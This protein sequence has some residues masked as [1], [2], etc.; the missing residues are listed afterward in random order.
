MP[1]QR[2]TCLPTDEA[3]AVF[4]EYALMIS[5]VAGVVAAALALLGPAVSAL[6]DDPALLDWLTP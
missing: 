3:G 6:F 4:L 5:L 2:A 1:P